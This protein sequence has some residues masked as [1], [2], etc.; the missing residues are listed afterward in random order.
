[1]PKKLFEKGK[2][3]NPGGRPK[4]LDSLKDLARTHTPEAFERLVFWM[5]SNNAKASV[6]AA[7]K[8]IDRGYGKAAQPLVGDETAP[9]IRVLHEAD[10][11]IIRRYLEGK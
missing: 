10:K 8:I 1:M 5:R 9:P 6:T 4:G 3:G 2:S 11:D 7:E